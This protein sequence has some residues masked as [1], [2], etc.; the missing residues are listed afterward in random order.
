MPVLGSEAR[1]V[2][3]GGPPRGFCAT[4]I[5]EGRIDGHRWA[6]VVKGAHRERVLRTVNRK[7][8]LTAPIETQRVITRKAPVQAQR[9]STT[10]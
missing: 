7:V 6:R 5:T 9:P 3:E 8:L 4:H 1:G 2:P 10:Y